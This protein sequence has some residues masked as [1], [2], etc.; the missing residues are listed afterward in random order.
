[1]K[2]LK[3]YLLALFFVVTLSSCYEQKPPM[4][5]KYPPKIYYYYFTVIEE[6]EF[7]AT[8]DTFVNVFDAKLIEEPVYTKHLIRYS[9]L[10][11]IEFNDIIVIRT[12]CVSVFNKFGYDITQEWFIDE[13]GKY[14]TTFSYREEMLISWDVNFKL[15]F[16]PSTNVFYIKISY[17]PLN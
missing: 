8:V 6:E 9:F 17:K 14:F 2:T 5:D 13:D 15:I 1:M 10:L 11:P 7:E 3:A 16:N 4:D 12:D